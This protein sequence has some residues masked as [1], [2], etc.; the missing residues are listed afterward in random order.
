MA[1]PQSPEEEGSFQGILGVMSCFSTIIL[2]YVSWP[3][4]F[5]FVCYVVFETLISYIYEKIR[6]LFHDENFHSYVK[7][8]SAFLVLVAY[9]SIPVLK[10]LNGPSSTVTVASKMLGK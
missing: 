8:F 10:W 1:I 6:R 9:G 4:E 7:T 3:V 2:K 5:F